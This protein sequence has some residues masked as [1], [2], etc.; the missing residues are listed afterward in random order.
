[1]PTF[2]TLDKAGVEPVRVN[3]DYIVAYRAKGEGLTIVTLAP[4]RVI[5][6]KNTVE[7][8]DAVLCPVEVT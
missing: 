1:M 7:D 3:T 2:I 5:T 4:D 8:I 6:V